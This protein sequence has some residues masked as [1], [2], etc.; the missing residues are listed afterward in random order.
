LEVKMS[1]L[2][3]DLRYSLR[4]LAKDSG[5][6]LIAVLSLALGIG[7]NSTVFSVAETALLRSW[8]AQAPERLAKIVARTPQGV[9][10]YF[11]YPDYHDLKQQSHAFEGILAWTRHGRTLRVGAE[12]REIL[13]D[14][15]SPNYFAVLGVSAQLGRTFSPS[16]SAGESTVVISDDLWRRH[17]SSDPSIVGRQIM[18]TNRAFTVIGIAAPG[19]RGLERGV[20]TDAW[21]PP[22]ADYGGE[23]PRD[24]GLR[25]FELLG[26]LRGGATPEQAQAELDVISHRLADAYPAYDKARNATLVPEQQ[27][28]RHAAFPTLLLMAAV[29]LVLLISSANVAGLVLARSETRRREIA[30]RRARGAGPGRRRRQGCAS[31]SAPAAAD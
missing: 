25:E 10:D 17:F 18:L 24:R 21:L 22:G 13:D 28:L 23:E 8:P 26:R 5:F 11:S 27:R 14:L 29:A 2:F 12:S 6:T 3:Q 4:T 31:R 9:D 30:V 20:P 19:F 1:S 16:T 15:V 7:A